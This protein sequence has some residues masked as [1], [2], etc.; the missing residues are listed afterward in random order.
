MSEITL[1]HNA[2]V[3]T[4]ETRLP[5]ADWFTTL[6]DKFQQIGAGPPPEQIKQRVDLGGATVVPGF[7]DAHTHFFQTGLDRL[8]IDLSTARNLADIERLLRAGNP[9]RR[10]WVF[11]HSYEEDL[12]E[13]VELLTRHHLDEILP[14]TP[15]WVNRIDYHSSVVNS[16]A[17]RRLEVPAGT[18]G[19]VLEGGRGGQPNGVLR[20][21]A[22][23]HGKARVARL[24]PVE[25][26]DRAVKTA[27]S[28]CIEHG[29]TAVHALE[30][31]KVFGDEGVTP[32]LKRMKTLP[33]DVT[34]FLQEK[35]V[36]FTQQLGFRHLGGCILIDGSIGSYTAALNDD[37][38]GRPGVQGVLYE[39]PREFAQFVEEAHASG[40]QLAFHAIGPRAIQQVL[41]AYE[42]A[43]RKFPR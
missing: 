7:V 43:L 14:E 2:K 13:D 35:N 26:K 20:A 19:L 42:R 40:V 6:G 16:V 28:A 15:L 9:G 3:H 22:Y 29:I 33:L 10:T 38:E 25:T 4:L 37:Y 27:A 24:Y 1:Y 32:I 21:D 31:G 12:L 17:L 34:I 8:F 36:Y 5:Q 23:F 18:R 39:K 30:G 11:A 41:D